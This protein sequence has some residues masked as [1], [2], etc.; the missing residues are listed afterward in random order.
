M[1]ND[2][3]KDEWDDETQSEDKWDDETP[4]DDW[5]E[6]LPTSKSPKRSPTRSPKRSPKQSKQLKELKSMSD[7]EKEHVGPYDKIKQFTKLP[8]LSKKLSKIQELINVVDFFEPT[9][10]SGDAEEDTL[11]YYNSIKEELEALRNEIVKDDEFVRIYTTASQLLAN[12]KL[13]EEKKRNTLNTEHKKKMQ[14]LERKKDKQERELISLENIIRR[15]GETPEKE[16]EKETLLQEISSL[17]YEISKEKQSIQEKLS[18][19]NTVSVSAEKTLNIIQEIVSKPIKVSTSDLEKLT[20][21]QDSIQRTIK[22]LEQRYQRETTSYGNKKFELLEEISK[23]YMKLT[24]IKDKIE[25]IKDVHLKTRGI[26]NKT[27]KKM[28]KNLTNLLSSKTLENI[29]VELSLL[30]LIKQQ[31]GKSI[32]TNYKDR[33][34]Y[35]IETAKSVRSLDAIKDRSVK[36][37][38]TNMLDF[39][40]SRMSMF[41]TKEPTKEDVD[42]IL[43]NIENYK[44]ILEYTT[45]LQD[46][47]EDMFNLSNVAM[48][49]DSM[50][51][52]I[53][54]DTKTISSIKLPMYLESY[55]SKLVNILNNAKYL[56][57]KYN[58]YVKQEKLLQQDIQ[59]I[60][61]DLK[62]TD[63]ELSKLY[64]TDERLCGICGSQ[65]FVESCVG[66][67]N[68]VCMDCR[69]KMIECPYRCGY[70]Y[71]QYTDGK[72]SEEGFGEKYSKE[73]DTIVAAMVSVS[74]SIG[75][76]YG[77][78]T[79]IYDL[80]EDMK[81]LVQDINAKYNKNFKV[82]SQ[83]LDYLVDNDVNLDPYEQLLVAEPPAAAIGDLEP[84]PTFG[85]LDRDVDEK[86][87]RQFEESK[88]ETKRPQADLEEDDYILQQIL[89]Q[90][91]LE[92]EQKSQRLPSVET[93]TP[94]VERTDVMNFLKDVYDAFVEDDYKSNSVGRLL[95]IAEDFR[96]DAISKMNSKYPDRYDVSNQDVM[97]NLL[98]MDIGAFI[99]MYNT[100]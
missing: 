48:F 86:L 29:R 16:K 75:N 72:D 19:L 17:N 37:L 62:L 66:C 34:N 44:K 23:Q 20:T 1:S 9:I 55:R 43:S 47:E 100:M 78:S 98:M 84:I 31:L 32:I 40:L 67:D 71:I 70:Q 33:L 95:S 74:H 93:K 76:R 77:A 13:V 2:F 3:D 97:E 27:L 87:Q 41:L 49:M 36:Q 18:D 94:S 56:V 63:T 8:E 22:N 46:S 83:V 5:G 58:T 59:L 96:T 42:V 64:E 4:S 24:E 88:A 61:E 39:V 79:T 69:R 89:E 14:E 99:M 85:G 80:I 81:K 30:D 54:K 82:F 25:N 60:K 12:N 73:M 52:K 15:R 6:E 91:R 57:D 7:D 65:R 26:L 28:E 50:V 35:I 68:K 38:A 51:S 92:Q 90:S 53:T 21:E 10:T 45:D 11:E